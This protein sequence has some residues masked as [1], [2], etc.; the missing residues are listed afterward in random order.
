MSRSRALAVL[1]SLVATLA[2]TVGVLTFTTGAASADPR[3][4]ATGNH[5]QY[6]PVPP[7]L[8]VNKGVVKY[9]TSVRATGRNYAAKEK[10]YITVY[11]RPKGSWKTRTV[12]TAAVRADRNGR[13]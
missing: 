6:P 2:M 11:F 3:G 1:S 7:S 10:V 4:H 12:K 8:V 9:G 13:F 5:N